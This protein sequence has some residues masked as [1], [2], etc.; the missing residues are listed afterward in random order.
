MSMSQKR[1][2]INVG[3]GALM[4]G[5]SP[6]WCAYVQAEP[7]EARLCSGCFLSAVRLYQVL[8][9]RRRAYISAEPLAALHDAT[10]LGILKYSI[11]STPEVRHGWP[12]YS[13][14][15]M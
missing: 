3:R 14:G 10:N 9:P 6:R 8:S 12:I 15:P 1:G 7:P 4:F 11:A 5:G 2:G 13:M